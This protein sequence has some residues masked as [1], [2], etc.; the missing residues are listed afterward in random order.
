MA[1]SSLGGPGHYE[2][3]HEPASRVRS[4]WVDIGVLVFRPRRHRWQPLQA[5]YDPSSRVGRIDYVV[6]SATSHRVDGFRIFVSCRRAPIEFFSPRLGI[7]N[8]HEFLAVTKLDCT[9]DVHAG[10]FR[11]GPGD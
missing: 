2:G 6:N 7:I 4:P 11:R 9:F 3:G 5:V 10:E 8:R 1:G